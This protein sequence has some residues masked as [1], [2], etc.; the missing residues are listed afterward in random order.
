M[1]ALEWLVLV[2]VSATLVYYLLTK[3][4]DVYPPGPI[5]FPLLGNLPQLAVLGS[6]TNYAQYYR[7]IYGDVFTFAF[8]SNNRVVISGYDNFYEL[9]VKRGGI[10][11]VR[12]P[13]S[14]LSQT[15][16]DLVEQT[17]GLLWAPYPHWKTLRSFSL[18]TLRE[19]GMGKAWMEPSIHDELEKYLAKFVEPN[20]NRPVELKH[21]LA[22]ATCN[23]ISQ[24]LYA[25]RFDF[26]DEKF[27]TMISSINEG[28]A[29]SIKIA[30]VS[31]LNIPGIT[32]LAKSIID[33]D[34]YIGD[35]VIRPTIQSYINEHK[36]DLDEN[37]PRNLTDRF[38]IHAQQV[39]ESEASYREDNAWVYN[40]QLYVAGTETTSTAL[41]WA[42]L[43]MCLYPEKRMRVQEEIDSVIGR[44]RPPTCKDRVSMSY[45]D[46]VLLETLRKSNMVS[47]A[48][49][50][51]LEKSI[52]ISGVVD[53]YCPLQ[54]IPA[55]ADLMLNM[56]SVLHDETVFEEPENFKPER[57]LTGDVALKKQRTIPF[58]IGRRACL[59][60]SLAR[61]EFFLFF[62]T[63]LQK[64]DIRLADGMRVTE[65]PVEGVVSTPQSHKVVF[66]HRISI[67]TLALVAATAALLYYLL[68]R[69][70]IKYPP[71]PL[72]FPLLG[73]LPQLVF[74]GSVPKYAKYYRK[75]YGDVF[76]FTFG[77]SRRVIISGYDNFYQLL[78]K[79]G[80]IT[81]SRTPGSILSKR[82]QEIV[83][84]TPGLFWA[85]YP[86]WK[87]LRSFS[88]STL[89]EEGMGKTT[90]EP[91]ILQ[92]IGHYC[93][94]FIEPN[95]SSPIELKHSLAQAT[96]N[97]I[98]QMMYAKRFDYDDEKFNRLIAAVDE[99]LA[100]GVKIAIT[101]NINIPGIEWLLG[102]TMERDKYLNE[103]ILMPSLQ[104]YIDEHKADL[105]RENPRD[106]TD[107]F[108]IHAERS[109][110]DSCYSEH[111]NCIYELQLYVA[112]TETTSTALRWAMLLM[113]RYPEKKKRV[114][115]EIDNIIGKEH[116]TCKDRVS[117]PYTD[118]VLLETLRKSNMVSTA[119]PH[120]LDEEM[121]IDGVTIPAGAELMLNM[122][123][124]LHDEAV[125]EEPEKFKPERYLTGDIALKKQRT[126]PFGLGRRACLGESLARM[127]F[128]LFFTTF[129]Q[130]Y[131]IR[132][133][134]ALT[135]TE[136]P[137][138][139]IVSTPKPYQI[140]FSRREN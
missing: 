51:T 112:G 88:L 137:I 138:E 14:F 71:G 39:G 95:L 35:N 11:S 67:G 72:A 132:L 13:R 74:H 56:A 78:V 43:F 22:Q 129:L 10:T 2:A 140:I 23:V 8:G 57:Y 77:S 125:F 116:P 110:G 130:K 12:S 87:T 76:T 90:L 62:T 45:T 127:E 99:S 58:G 55:G 107:R 17:P 18:S 24:M 20:L 61:M 37:N 136:E 1:V 91:Q 96:C 60:E 92:E 84:K 19:E 108:L 66:S 123:S 64:Y 100:L 69:D 105:D 109:D 49:P 139:M 3:K 32:W 118:A 81:S 117:M 9:L 111:N 70:K 28:L 86:H 124:V 41:C 6:L 68:T 53:I 48:L 102:S 44:D 63:F 29:L 119:L 83:K 101:A 73:N 7:K 46:A 131:D 80:D 121:I 133:A 21:S 120:T 128:F 113:C 54:N 40:M 65:E 5:A 103:E 93:S 33:R 31:C 122:G 135:A 97:V 30:L 82:T 25:K 50:H 16:K 47:T 75:V 115:E 134:D 52:T 38:L 36:A 42:I 98:S 59:G 27:N 106:L 34:R 79:R 94:T 114:Q 104:S 89:R 126:I 85:P 26:D 4:R 15:G